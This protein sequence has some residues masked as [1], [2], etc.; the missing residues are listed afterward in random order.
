M[1]IS[2]NVSEIR[3]SATMAVAARARELRAAGRD[4]IDL[5]AGEPDFR[6]PDFIAEAGIAAIR[7]GHTRYAPPPGI[8]ALR[9]AIAAIM[10]RRFHRTID[11]QGI[12]VSGGA[13][14]ALFNACFVLFG[15]GDRVLLPAPYWTSYPEII[16]LARAEPVLVRGP[17]ER[18]FKL[19]PEE[20]DAAYDD[21]VRGLMLNSPSNPT[22]AVYTR[23][24]LDAIVRWAVERGIWVIS[25]E[26]YARIHFGGGFATGVLD[27][28]DVPLD[29]VVIIDGAS[30][31][32]AMTG[33]RVGFSYTDPALA[34]PIAALQSHTTSGTAT[35]SQYAALAAYSAEPLEEEALT[36]M[37]RVFRRRRDLVVERFRERLPELPF[38]YPDGAFYLFFRADGRYGGE[39]GDSV[40]FCR[41]LLDRAD[42]AL[43]PGAA[44]GD[45]RF[46]R[47]SFAAADEMLERGI[48][49]LAAVLTG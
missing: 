33:W 3:P 25:D 13:K 21:R 11:P 40:A 7:Q 38:V 17:E 4:I 2:E 9:E 44:F 35:P 10:E 20:L 24:E 42:V 45:D 49:R 27:L 34:K 8:P 36:T 23:E 46:V 1:R 28:D 30:K 37:T 32:Y 15:P 18:G 41:D 6:T 22:G 19:T 43:V 26:I 29:R 39:I 12:V 14:Q 16:R 47:L 48:A 31:G 5:S